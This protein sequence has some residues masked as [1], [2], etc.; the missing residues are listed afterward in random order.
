MSGQAHINDAIR[1]G[2]LNIVLEYIGNN[3]VNQAITDYGA[4]SLWLAS[5]KGK[6]DVVRI[7]HDAG[8]DVNQAPTDDGATP[9]YIASQSGMQK[10]VRH[11]TIRV[12]P[13]SVSRGV[14][15]GLRYDTTNRQRTP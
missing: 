9:L 2:D 15:R 14:N 3:D 8:A 11:V 1:L 10:L 12:C 7:L 5:Y 6:A 13:C 4:T